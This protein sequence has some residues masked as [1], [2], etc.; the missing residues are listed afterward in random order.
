[1]FPDLTRDDIFQLETS[2]LWLRWPRAV[3]AAKMSQLAGDRDVAEMTARLPHPYSEADAGHFILGARSG[4]AEGRELVLVL[5]P[6]NRPREVL[7]VI[8][9]HKSTPEKLLLGFWLGKAHWGQGLMSEA[10]KAML[11]LAFQITP[12]QLIAAETLTT[13]VAAQKVLQHF[14]FALMGQFETN[15]LARGK[16]NCSRFHL[17]RED[18]TPNMASQT[19]P[20]ELST[21]L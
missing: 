19:V 17:T 6:K 5:T 14:G 7:G 3:D 15:A 20:T 8:S 4:N 1:M 18:W 9:L 10:T 11:D 21:A 16:I 12:A 13:N 2:R